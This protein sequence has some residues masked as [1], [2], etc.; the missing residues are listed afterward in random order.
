MR[1]AI[2]A[3][4][5]QIMKNLDV[6]MAD[7]MHQH[8]HFDFGTIIDFVMKPVD[9]NDLVGSWRRIEPENSR[10]DASQFAHTENRS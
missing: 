3:C 7:D 10:D 2:C 5:S 4:I 9:N 1:V 6:L 8:W